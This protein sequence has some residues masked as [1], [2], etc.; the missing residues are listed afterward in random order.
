MEDEDI[1]NI[2]IST[3]NHL[4]FKE[5]DRDWGNDSFLSFAEVLEM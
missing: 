1:F 5:N 4:G 3:D 2:L